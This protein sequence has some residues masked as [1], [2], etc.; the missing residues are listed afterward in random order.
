[1]LLFQAC[2]KNEDCTCATGE[3][4]LYLLN[5]F[6]TLENS[7]AIIEPTA[8]I[9]ETPLIEYSGFI[10]YHTKNHTFRITDAARADLDS[11]EHSVFGVPFAV[12]A[13]KHLIYTG[14]FWP[15]YSSATCEWIIIDPILVSGENDLMVQLGYPGLA[16]GTEIPDK[17]NSPLILDIFRRD[18]K[19]IE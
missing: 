5:S 3:V 11:M 2:S 14:Y 13:D 7:C 12:V 15:A 10:S 17:R 18:G 19:L 1:M 4:E 9:Q 8:V 6:E 16:E